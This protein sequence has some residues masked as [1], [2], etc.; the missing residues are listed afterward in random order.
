MV[1]KVRTL[2]APS[3][4]MELD[5]GMATSCRMC[6]ALLCRCGTTV[7]LSKNKKKA[8]TSLT[9]S[10]S[11]SW[12]EMTCS[13]SPALTVF[14]PKLLQYRNRFCSL[15]WKQLSPGNLSLLTSHYSI[16]HSESKLRE[17]CIQHHK[18]HATYSFI[19]QITVLH[20]STRFNPSLHE[21]DLY[22]QS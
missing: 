10:L 7:V 21:S 8:S 9:A 16:I 19:K 11:R 15:G 22:N 18:H 2:H 5:K 20:S 12:L 6:C 4:C 13:P 3:N 1:L 14:P 17:R